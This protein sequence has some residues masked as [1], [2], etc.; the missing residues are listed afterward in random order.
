MISMS[1]S[2]SGFTLAALTLGLSVASAACGDEPPAKVPTAAPPPVAASACPAK[3]PAVDDDPAKTGA[4]AGKTVAKICLLGVT[5]SQAD[6]AKALKTKE[7]DKLDLD[8]VRADL[9]AIVA[10]RT[11]EDVSVSA[12]AQGEK[13][14]KVVLVYDLHERP[15]IAEVTFD[16]ANVFK[17][18]GL[19]DKVP[20][21]K[22]RPF[23]AA[24]AKQLSIA[25]REEYMHRGYG[26]VKI[27]YKAE[28]A[29]QNLV[30]LNYTVVEGPQWK[31][32]KVAF[33][34]NTKVGEAELKKL[35]Q[36]ETGKPFDPALIERALVAV[37]GKYFDKGYLTARVE[38]TTD[39][40]DAQGNV[41]TT[42]TLEEG[43]LYRV[44]N[45]GFGKLGETMGKE[46][47]P[48]IKMRP[49]QV[50]DRSLLMNDI[51]KLKAFY[52]ARGKSVEVMPLTQLDPKK[53]TVDLI[54]EIEELPPGA[55]P[56]AG[57]G[58]P[59]APPKPGAAA[60]VVGPA[61]PAAGAKPSAAAPAP[62]GPAAPGAGAGGAPKPTMPAT[63]GPSATPAG[64]PKF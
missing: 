5:D 36:L 38:N 52:K 58:G 44:G 49:T 25:L 54:L 10:L 22:H 2:V 64:A 32:A 50:F 20:L 53:K 43:D 51:D 16:G 62:I 19:A 7:G 1:R 9:A 41:A 42:I 12:E 15:R 34:G 6:V 46:L 57:P 55:V 48:V 39:A 45:M 35:S 24:E 33:K 4:L 27:Q 3:A 28:P 60:P 26:G 61:A 37:Q 18:A 11:I 21:E 47:V 40:P 59:G 23:L 31:L 14:E 56:A 8:K 30:R 17:E 63:M 13:G 29:G